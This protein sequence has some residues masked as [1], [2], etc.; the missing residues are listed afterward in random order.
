MNLDMSLINARYL[1][2]H[3]NKTVQ[4]LCRLL[5]GGPKIYTRAQLVAMGYPQYKKPHSDEIDYD[6]EKQEANSI[7][8][9]FSLYNRNGLWVE[10]ELRGYSWDVNS[11]IRSQQ[12]AHT[13][14]TKSLVWLINRK[15]I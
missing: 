11:L 2:L 14:Y 12:S 3:D 15:K 13:P 1:L 7:Y 9:V 8:I 6:K 10:N 4:P 5:K